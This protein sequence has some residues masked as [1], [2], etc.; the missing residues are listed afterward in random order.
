[1]FGSKAGAYSSEALTMIYGRLL[2]LPTK[3]RLGWK[4]LPGTNALAY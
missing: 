4:S 2:T 1:M 3:A